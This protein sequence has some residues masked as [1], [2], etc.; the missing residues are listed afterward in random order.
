MI[1]E[2]AKKIRLLILDVDGVLTDGR[3]IYD[4]FGDELKFFNVHD[5]FGMSLLY[6]AGIKSVIITA[7]KTRIVKRRAKDMHIAALY[8][9]HKKF[10]V[11]QKVLKK[12]R[13]KHEEV[14]FMGDDLLDLP[15]MK[16]VGLAAAPP[17]AVE[18][19]KNSSHYITQKGGGKGAV[20]EVIE[21]ILKS[22]G[23]WDKALSS[24]EGRVL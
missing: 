6:R 1:D 16:K 8:S 11:Y 15:V 20:R 10:K 14:C 13:V 9:S 4:N 19:V 3:I 23:L 22:Q 17:N 2:R 5:G 18:E 21:M 12:F 24:F 7:K